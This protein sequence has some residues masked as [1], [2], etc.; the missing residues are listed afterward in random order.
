MSFQQIRD[1]LKKIL[2]YHKEL[3]SC[4]AEVVARENLDL[5]DDGRKE[6]ITK[7]VKLQSEIVTKALGQLQSQTNDRALDTWI[8]Y[9]PDE[10]IHRSLQKLRSIDNPSWEDLLEL[11]QSFDQAVRNLCWTLADQSSLPDNKELFETLGRV[12]Q[13]FLE[14]TTWGMRS[15][16]TWG[17]SPKTD[18]EPDDLMTDETRSI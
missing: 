14:Q 18:L 8:Q 17:E 2:I 9:V 15:E 13:S 6:W 5:E 7:Y 12:S 3:H 16:T 1:I 11:V 10:E 4:I